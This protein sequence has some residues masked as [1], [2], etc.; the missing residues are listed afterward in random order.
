VVLSSVW[1]ALLLAWAAWLFRRGSRSIVLPPQRRR[2]VPWSGPEVL[3]VL[4][5]SQFFWPW[6][7]A[8]FLGAVGFFQRVYGPEFV[9]GANP[10]DLSRAGLW[11]KTF[12]LPLNLVGLPAL[13]YVLS[14]T[15]PYQLGLTANRALRNV[16]LGILT[17]I[18]VV[19][20]VYLILNA[21]T[22][23]LKGVGEAPEEH[24]LTKLVHGHPLTIDLVIGA[25]VAIVAAPI[26]EELLFRGIVQPWFRTHRGGGWWGIGGALF[27]AMVMRWQGIQSGWDHGWAK[28]W[29][30]LLP[31]GFVLLLAL[32]YQWV[33]TR[34][35]PA[36][37]A[38]YATSVLFAA[39]HSSVWPSPVPLFFFAL[40]LGALRYRTQS[41]VAPVAT[42]GLFNLVGWVLTLRT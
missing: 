4:I 41:L 1:L 28:W 7:L 30:E 10:A 38:I 5:V 12:S 39:A 15:R 18:C 17:A 9:A 13:L 21:V 32:G 8:A 23:L 2:A 14:D 19:P 40:V 35:S 26:Q 34:L 36:A 27:L 24:P 42:H 3:L 25:L 33:S 20:V 31:A 11:L 22:W 37:E 6:S 16:L 29:P